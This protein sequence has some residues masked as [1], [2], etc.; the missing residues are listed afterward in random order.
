MKERI[1]YVPARAEANMPEQDTLKRAMNRKRQG[2][3]PSTQA[4]DLCE[5]RCITSVKESTE[6]DLP[7]KR[8]PLGSR[9]L[10]EPVWICLRQSKGTLL[11]ERELRR[12]GTAKK[13]TA[14]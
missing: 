2:K 13:A 12:N 4:G 10:A 14:M 5:K 3:K 8:S 7:N 9:K 11:S 6:R 1:R